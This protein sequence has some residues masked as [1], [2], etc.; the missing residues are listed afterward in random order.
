MKHRA[1]G[2]G[3]KGAPAGVLQPGEAEQHPMASVEGV[4]S[5]RL[6]RKCRQALPPYCAQKHMQ[7]RS[8]RRWQVFDVPQERVAVTS[9]NAGDLTHI[10]THL[11]ER[12]RRDTFDG[13]P[14]LP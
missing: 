2:G 6:R 9:D 10:K 12:R 5:N 11:R 8:G 7:T 3:G 14:N 13:W 1:A 4:D